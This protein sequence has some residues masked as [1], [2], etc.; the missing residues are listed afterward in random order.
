MASMNCTKCRRTVLAHRC[1][2]V[3]SAV[4]TE[5]AATPAAHRCGGCAGSSNS[6]GRGALPNGPESI[7]L[8]PEQ[9]TQTNRS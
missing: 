1:V 8:K 7:K 5:A 6:N 9:H 4:A 2:A 3:I